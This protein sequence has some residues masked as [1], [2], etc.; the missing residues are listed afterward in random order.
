MAAHPCDPSTAT[1]SESYLPT[2]LQRLEELIGLEEGPN[3]QR[4]DNSVCDEEE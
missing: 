2:R 1:L 4:I 3:A